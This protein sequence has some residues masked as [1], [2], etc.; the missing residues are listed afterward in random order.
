MTIMASVSIGDLC[1]RPTDLIDRVI[2]GEPVVITRAGIAVA[3]LRRSGT[4]GLE[5]AEILLRWRALPPVDARVWRDDVDH[6]FDSVAHPDSEKGAP[7]S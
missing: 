7:S 5:A 2:E 1:S 6:V 4:V 3:E